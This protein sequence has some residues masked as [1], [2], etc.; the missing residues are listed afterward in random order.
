MPI[1]VPGYRDRKGRASVVKR[2]VVALLSLTAMVDLFTVLVVFLLQSYNVTGE[3]IDISD[4]VLLPQAVQTKDL[5]PA[6]VVV[7]S[8][9]E[10]LFNGE[11]VANV[12]SLRA[13]Q[14]WMI[15]S[16]LAQTRGAIEV[17]EANEKSLYAKIK[18]GVRQVRN[19]PADENDGVA[20]V[21]PEYRKATV[22]ADKSI[23]FLTLKKVL[24]TLTE[25]G[26]IEI[27]FAVIKSP[28]LER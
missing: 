11:Q 15:E 8:P 19:A 23:R 27:N 13:Q 21:V 24:Y 28:E 17:G 3:V 26:I 1:Y 10:L 14:H 4:E 22:Q 6:H 2:N 16:L 18:S 12:S 9:D 25:A 20:A 7:L 5:T